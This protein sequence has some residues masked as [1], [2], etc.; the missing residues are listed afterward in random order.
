MNGNDDCMVFQILDLKSRIQDLKSKKLSPTSRSGYC[1]ENQRA[2]PS[3][4]VGLPPRKSKSSALPH[5][6]ATAPKIKELSAPSQ[7]GYCPEWPRCAFVKSEAA[8][9][10]T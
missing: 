2:E 10:S 8:R 6:R 7:S 1:P 9:Q 3:L 4:T 5:G